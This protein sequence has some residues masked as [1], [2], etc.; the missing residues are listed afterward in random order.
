VYVVSG[1]TPFSVA[2][3]ILDADVDTGVGADAAGALAPVVLSNAVLYAASLLNAS[4]AALVSLNAVA[5]GQ[6]IILK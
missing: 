6:H 1:A 3:Y 2:K 5:D 4:A